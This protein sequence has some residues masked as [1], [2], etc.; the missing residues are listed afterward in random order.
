M[1][2][3]SFRGLLDIRASRG[4]QRRA[5]HERA[6]AE[7]GDKIAAERDKQDAVPEAQKQRTRL[8]IK[9]D[10]GKTERVKLVTEDAKAHAQDLE[11]VSAAADTLRGR[12]EQAKRRLEALHVLAD[13]VKAFREWRERERVRGLQGE[14]YSD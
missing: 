10:Q 7:T 9:I 6:I 13:D 11:K 5:G 14:A 4:R 1:G 3:E 8:K 12:I 2:A